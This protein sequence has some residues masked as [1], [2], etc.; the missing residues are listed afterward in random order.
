MLKDASK[1]AARRPSQAR[2]TNILQ[3]I[4]RFFSQFPTD[5]SHLISNL[6]SEP[7]PQTPQ[8][9]GGLCSSDHN[10][11]QWLNNLKT[12]TCLPWLCCATPAGNLE[13][14]CSLSSSLCIKLGCQTNMWGKKRNK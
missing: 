9:Y 1:G 13:E 6:V 10:A 8:K 5:F 3:E 14:T 4:F 11:F 7:C 2:W 12:G